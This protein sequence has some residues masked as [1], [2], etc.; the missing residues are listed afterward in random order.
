[1]VLPLLG[2]VQRAAETGQWDCPTICQTHTGTS[3]LMNPP[4]LLIPIV[5]P[6]RC[7]PSRCCFTRSLTIFFHVEP[8][9]DATKPAAGAPPSNATRTIPSPHAANAERR[10]CGYGWEAGLGPNGH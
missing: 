7:F 2:H 9:P 6:R 4:S 5:L 1:M 8:I 10:Q 3:M